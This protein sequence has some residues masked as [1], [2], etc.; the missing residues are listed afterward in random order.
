LIDMPN[1]ILSTIVDLA[2]SESLPALRLTNKQLRVVSDTPFA[3]THFLERRHVQTAFSMNGLAEITA[4][5][6]F[7][8]FVRTVII[9]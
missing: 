6:F 4:H 1:E 3:T 2:G 8:K 7:G 9:S 5:P